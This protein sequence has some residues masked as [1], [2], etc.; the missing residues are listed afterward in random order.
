MNEKSRKKGILQFMTMPIWLCIFFVASSLVFL[1]YMVMKNEHDNT[2]YLQNAAKQIHMSV[3]KQ[4]EGDMQTLEGLSVGLGSLGVTDGGQIMRMLQNINDENAFIRMGYA[5]L[6]GNLD[7][8]DIG[9]RHHQVNV[10]E[11]EFFQRALRGEEAISEAF[12]DLFQGGAYVNYYGVPMKDPQGKLAGILCGVHRS[13]ILREIIDTPLLKNQGYSDI[14]DREG[15]FILRSLASMEANAQEDMERIIQEA[16]AGGGANSSF[17]FKSGKGEDCMAVLLPLSAKGWCLFSAI[18]LKTLRARYMETAIG[19]MA[20][21][22]VA[23]VLL[24]LLLIRQR[25]M[26]ARNQEKLMRLAYEDSLTGIRNF[27]GLKKT[28]AELFAARNP[29]GFVMWYCDVKTSNFSTTC[30][31]MKTGITF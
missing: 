22:V 25:K 17:R 9:G 21:I 6:E 23:C 12:P 14:V 20:I 28:A 7:L 5:D 19:I 30:W 2:E 1:V 26:V 31:D 29:A 15:R 13:Q 18:P 27:D 16:M 10:A 4:I 24:I 3:V 11:K 8:V